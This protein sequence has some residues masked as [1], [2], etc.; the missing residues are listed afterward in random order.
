MFTGITQTTGMVEQK[1]VCSDNKLRVRINTETPYFDDS[2]L[3]DSIMVDGV[4]LTIVS[5][6]KKWALFDI[7]LPTCETTIIKNYQL[8]Q[9]VNL[10]KAMLASDRIDG[11]I[12]LRHVDDTAKVIDSEMIE[13]TTILTLSPKNNHL[14]NQIVSKGSIAILGVS[15]TVVQAT[16]NT[17]KIGLIPY[18]MAHTN[19]SNLKIGQIV[20]IETDIL[21]KYIAGRKND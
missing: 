3:G 15:L 6:N 13:T 1:E 5:R 14:M 18:T 4:C 19:L 10:E 7:M 2:Q 16:E 21:A 12:V 20:N 8:G 11:H 9:I 17:F